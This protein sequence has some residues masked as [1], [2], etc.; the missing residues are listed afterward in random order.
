MLAQQKLSSVV[1]GMEVYDR[2]GARV[3][4]VKAFRL[5]EGTIKTSATDIVTIAE[6]LKE[7]IGDKDLPTVMYSRLFDEGFASV[8]RGFLRGDGIV[9]PSQIDE[10]NGDTIYLT[11]NESELFKL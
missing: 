2:D 7:T 1:K 11:V 9:F 5:G 6:T 10:I 8:D 3:G 4:T